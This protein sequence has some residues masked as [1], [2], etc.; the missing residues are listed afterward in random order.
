MPRCLLWLF[1]SDDESGLPGKMFDHVASHGLAY[2][3]L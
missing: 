1:A 2:K 3:L